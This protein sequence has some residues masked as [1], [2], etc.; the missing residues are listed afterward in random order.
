VNTANNFTKT[1]KN[2]YDDIEF[3]ADIKLKR[4]QN[5]IRIEVRDINDK[6]IPKEFVIEIR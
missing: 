1:I 6:I 5:R 4:G 3:E 2:F